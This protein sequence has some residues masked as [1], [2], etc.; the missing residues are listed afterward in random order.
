MNVKS[1]NSI[2]LILVVLLASCSPDFKSHEGNLEKVKKHTSDVQYDMDARDLIGEMELQR[3]V[4]E[5]EG[6]QDFYIRKQSLVVASFPCTNCH[7]ED[8]RKLK[9]GNKNGEKKAHWDI[10]IVHASD[11]VMDCLTCHSESNLD[12]LNSITGAEIDFDMSYKSCAQCHST[13]YKEWQGGSHGKRVGGWVP[14]R[15]AKTCVECHDPHNPAFE[16]RWPSRL[17]TTKLTD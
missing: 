14:P 9:V 3:V 6:V 17:N 7:N 2:F 15:I 1:R 12:K 13:Q 10:K 4:P 8:L 5:L 11:N 16:S